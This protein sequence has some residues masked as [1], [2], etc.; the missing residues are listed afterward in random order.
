MK[1]IAN[2]VLLC[3]ILSIITKPVNAQPS[4]TIALNFHLFNQ[5]GKAIELDEFY[6][7]FRLINSQGEVKLYHEPNDP[8]KNH[9][10]P[11]NKKFRLTMSTVYVPLELNIIHKTDTMTLHVINSD[12]GADIFI[13]SL[14]FK[15]GMYA[16]ACS[17]R[18]VDG[19]ALPRVPVLK[20]TQIDY[21][22]AKAAYYNYRLDDL[23][24]RTRASNQQGAPEAAKRFCDLQ[25]RYHID[26]NDMEYKT[27]EQL[28]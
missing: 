6:N 20:L 21:P 22:D 18:I 28:Q 15:P 16:I 9:Y 8:K 11:S 27:A 7:D 5:Q 12:Y 1:K 13:D 14:V 10:N 24:R 3:I 19:K 4:F 25:I 17:S 23:N 2:V 26:K